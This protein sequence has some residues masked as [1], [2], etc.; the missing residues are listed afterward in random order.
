ME[1]KCCLCGART[2]KRRKRCTIHC[3]HISYE[4]SVTILLC[5]SCHTIVTNYERNPT[6]YNIEE[7][8]F[9]VLKT[10]NKVKGATLAKEFR[11]TIVGLRLNDSDI[12]IL[13]ERA[14]KKGL[15]IGGYIKEQILKS[16]H[17]IVNTIRANKLAELQAS[18]ESHLT[19]DSSH[20]LYNPQKRY[21]VG[22]RVLVRRGK[23]LI[24]TVVPELD[25]D[26]NSIPLVL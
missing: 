24:E 23:K 10:Y 13:K 9:E 20:K 1:R 5:I 4:P 7:P 2:N 18:I 14:D 15:S 12:A 25:A 26:G 17:P 11:T 22:D 8:R 19:A 16:L 3:H 6:V 21:N